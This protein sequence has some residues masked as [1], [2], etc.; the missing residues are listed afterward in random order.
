MSR[1]NSRQELKDYAL[2]ALGHPVIL[3]N[4][5]DD[6]LEDRIDDALQLFY[7]YHADGSEIV[8]LHHQIT[9]QEKETKTIVL[10]SDVL[11]VLSVYDGT[12]AA[13]GGS[14]GIAD[15]NLQYQAFITD[16]LNGKRLTDGGV[17][18]FYVTMTY[19]QGL[20]DTFS[21]P[22]RKEFNLHNNKLSMHGDW[23]GLEVGHWVAIECYR[24][25]TELTTADVFNNYWLKQYVVA[26]FKY[27]WG[28]NLMKFSGVTLPGQVQV[29][30]EGIFGAGQAEKDKLEQ[31]LHDKYELPPAFFTG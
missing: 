29:N 15:V 17:S 8:F 11:S 3:I 21:S 16:F 31:E 22:S 12:A 6:Q 10:P 14:T 5:D 9:Q 13:G 24:P 28:S 26:L 30:A 19:L 27:Q 23:A 4:V 1:I 20:S 2:R 18:K 7:Q 25:V